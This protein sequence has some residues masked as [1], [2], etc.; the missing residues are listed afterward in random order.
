[1]KKRL[2]SHLGEKPFFYRY[3]SRLLSPGR[4]DQ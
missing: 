2:S 3:L 1:M 4:T